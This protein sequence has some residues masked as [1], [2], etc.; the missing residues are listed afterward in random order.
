MGCTSKISSDFLSAFVCPLFLF[1]RQSVWMRISLLL[2]RW[3]WWRKE[4]EGGVAVLLFVWR[5]GCTL[6]VAIH[7]YRPH[8]F[9]RR[10]TS[11]AAFCFWL[12]ISESFLISLWE[13]HIHTC[14]SPRLSRFREKHYTVGL[15]ERVRWEGRKNSFCSC[16]RC[17][18][19]AHAHCIITIICEINS[20]LPCDIY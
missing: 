2:L 1:L 3:W 5:D 12:R 19:F 8:G 10:R 13:I 11:N 17:F 18:Y 7:P 9:P 14:L 20:F 4:E 16:N 15:F 6:A